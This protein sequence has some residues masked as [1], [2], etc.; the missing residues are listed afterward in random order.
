[1]SATHRPSSS[2]ARAFWPRH[3]RDELLARLR[4]G[5]GALG[6]ELDVRRA[7]LIGSWAAGRHMAA[8]DVDLL[9]VYSG[10]ARAD[11]YALCRKIV[12]VP[13]LQPHVYSEEEAAA[14]APTLDRMSR[15]G[16]VIR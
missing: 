14:L 9:V 1:M 3:S 7:V 15:G 8:S 5:V 13:R 16:V 11:A 2:S 6:R 4:E 12:A 10:P